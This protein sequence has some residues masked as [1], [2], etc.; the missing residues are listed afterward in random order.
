[1][2]DPL[3]QAHPSCLPYARAMNRGPPNACDCHI[4]AYAGRC[5][6]PPEAT[7]RPPDASVADYRALQASLG[8]SRVVV[9]TPSTYGTDN[10][11]TLDAL[12]AF[13][14]AARGV[15]VIGESVT[16]QELESL[17]AAGVRGIRLNL[18]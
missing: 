7:L 1:M 12:G 10:R 8:T 5:P 14:G 17:H 3:G 15:A 2:D 4:H 9:V 6:A 18:A 13:S 11:P 16:D